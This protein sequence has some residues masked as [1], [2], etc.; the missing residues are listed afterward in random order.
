MT[1]KNMAC[2]GSVKDSSLTVLRRIRANPSCRKLLSPDFSLNSSNQQGKCFGGLKFL[3]TLGKTDVVS[4][5]SALFVS[6]GWPVRAGE[7]EGVFVHGIG[8]KPVQ[9]FRQVDEVPNLPPREDAGDV[10]ASQRRPGFPALSS[11]QR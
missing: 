4:A 10:G 2:S 5:V 6:R 3:L 8:V 11:P 7:V 9:G 1:A